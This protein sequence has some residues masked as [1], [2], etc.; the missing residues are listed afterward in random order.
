MA[1][2]LTTRICLRNDLAERWSSVNPVLLAGEVGV[3][4]DT[5]LF[6]I[7]NG[8][9]TYSELSYANQGSGGGGSALIS[10]DGKTIVN[11]SN[12]L[13]LNNWGTQYYAYNSTTHTYSLQ[14]VDETHPWKAGLTPRAIEENGELVLAWF[15]AMDNT[16]LL[17]RLDNIEVEVGDKT[18]TDTSTL[19]G[20]INNKVSVSGGTL[21]GSLIAA[22]GTE[23]ASKKYVGEQISQLNALKRIIVENLP[24]VEDADQNAIYMVLKSSS[25]LNNNYEEYMVVDGAF[26][27]IGSTAVDLANYLKRPATYTAANLPKFDDNG[28][29]ADSGIG[30]ESLLSHLQDTTIHLNSLQKQKLSNLLPIY[31]LDSSLGFTDDGKLKVVSAPAQ[32]IPLATQLT[33]GVV[34]ASEEV[35]VD[36]N[37]A[38]GIGKISISKLVNDDATDFVLF[39][40]NAGTSSNA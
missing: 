9:S 30:A 4:R 33:A 26:E 7:G 2:A 8:T 24:P 11:P 28:N 18:S 37:G 34:K 14:V 3:E 5:G 40:G 15:E 36:E 21:L 22:D 6:K 20:A 1:L 29:I 32:D 10:T 12:V 38:L 31:E 35:T 17:T 39:G 27:L 13:A 25:L 19:W 16:T 23:V